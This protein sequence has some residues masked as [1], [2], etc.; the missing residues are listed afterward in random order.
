MVRMSYSFLFHRGAD[1]TAARAAKPMVSWWSKGGCE[2]PKVG[3]R[4]SVDEVFHQVT[5]S[6]H[7][8]KVWIHKNIDF[9]LKK[10]FLSPSRLVK[11]TKTF[12]WVVKALAGFTPTGL[13]VRFLVSIPSDVSFDAPVDGACCLKRLN[14][15][16]VFT[17][18]LIETS[19]SKQHQQEKPYVFGFKRTGS[20][21]HHEWVCLFPGLP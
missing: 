4:W 3:L 20:D 8:S 6:F 1:A 16:Q 2:R 14:A 21:T 5:W 15:T 19:R 9:E 13:K 17:N 12:P 7:T 18:Q 10:P 11:S